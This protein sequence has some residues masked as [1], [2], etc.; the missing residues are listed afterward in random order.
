MANQVITTS[1]NHDAL[2]GRNAGEDITIQEGAVL[3][4]DSMPHLT[5][6][7][8]LGQ[9]TYT[10]G[11]ILID[12]SRTY[13]VAYSNGAGG[14]LPAVG[15][16]ISW[17]AG[18]DTGKVVRLNSGDAASG[19]LTLT[20]DS[21]KVT[22][23]DA[24]SITDGS[25][26][27]D[28]DSVKIGFLIVFGEDQDWVAGDARSTI[29]ITG[30]WYELGT[31]TGLDSQVLTLPHTGHQPAIWVETGDGTNVFQIW[32]RIVPSA[33]IIFYNNISQFGNTFESGFVFDQSF[34]SA[35]VTFGTST[36]GGVPPSGARIRIP[37]VH[38]GTTTVGS[39]TT[40]V[41]TASIGNHIRV[42]A[43]G[44]N[45]NVEIDHLNASSVQIGFNGTNEVTCSDSCWGLHPN[46]IL[47]TNVKPTVTLTNCAVIQGSIG[48]TGDYLPATALQIIDSTG[49]V[50]LDGCVLMS[51]EDGTNTPYT[52]GLFT[53][54]NVAFKGVCKIVSNQQNE[55]GHAAIRATNCSNVTAETLIV[56]GGYLAIT[57]GSN[58]WEIDELIYGLPPGRG[59]TQINIVN[60]LSHNGSKECIVHSGR[61]AT[62]AIYGTSGI[63]NLIDSDTVTI[64]GFGA[65]D[66]KIDCAARATYVWNIAGISTN[67]RLQRLW[68][69]NLN[70]TDT[71]VVVNA[72]KG[73]V[74]ENCSTDY[75]DECDDKSNETIIKGLH[76]ASGDPD[77]GTGFEGDMSNVVGTC[78]YNHFK[79]DTTG[80]IGLLFNDPGDFH[81][82]DVETVA[83]TPVWNGLAD[84][85]LRTT[86]DQVVYTYPYS[87]KGHTGFQNAA[88]QVSAVG[89]YTYEYDLDTGSGYSGSW[90]AINGA[91]L[92]AESISPA[93]FRFKVRITCTTTNTGN[94]IKGF[95][96][97]TTTT[98]ADQAANLYPLEQIAITVTV[99]SNSRVQIYNVTTDTEI[100]N[101]F[102]T[103]TSFSTEV[104]TEA[105]INDVIR[106]RVTKKG[107]KETQAVGIFTGAT[108]G[109][110]VS[111]EIDSV[112]VA[113][114][115][116]GDTVTKFDP[117][118]MNDQVD[119]NISSNFGGAEFYAWYNAN[120][121]TEEGIR[122]FY[123]AVTAIDEG[124]IRINSSILNLKFDNLTSSNVFQNDNIRISRSDS[125]YP[126]I[127]P[128]TGGGGID[129]NWRNVVFIAETGVSGLTAGEAATLAKI[130]ELTED[131]SGVRFTAKA[132]EEGC[133]GEFYF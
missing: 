34:G 84:L 10:D 61:L 75:S 26:T 114:G 52:F 122:K 27:A 17:N 106:I 72:A 6:M 91:N 81:A 119:L 39:P 62:G 63:F 77:S 7:G 120:L 64:R 118:Y 43:T 107:Y 40:E 103:G 128:T 109:F 38:L 132:L 14:S 133:S 108:L 89:S 88:I 127:N 123:G 90:T 21:G 73:L 124:N 111:Q 42:L 20:K 110:L 45:L 95:A 67:I 66:A 105:S 94:A 99:L 130:D 113:Y 70:A 46:D 76:V 16:A 117:D 1:T 53:S 11:R 35:T 41:S 92:S 97:R 93:G 12:G 22:P 98:L 100:D 80:A 121:A 9:L 112:Y 87:I 54:A 47:V 65:I 23:D 79:S 30:D 60:A 48:L 18:V 102:V 129:I 4:I 31:G 74:I 51:G 32:H 25:W 101:Q 131:V 36:A 44:T 86:G 69:T 15:T 85:L 83:G 37:N 24:D 3:T 104:T 49:G 19:V 29:K 28:L 71:T 2:T 96:V 50:T 56:L 68:F 57:T 125:D 33:S 13:E 116:D 55:N 82:S 115:I 78:F 8:I 5:S 59:T 126:I 58:N